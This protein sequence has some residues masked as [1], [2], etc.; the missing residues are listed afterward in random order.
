MFKYRLINIK[1]D[2]EILL[3]PHCRINYES[4]TPYSGDWI[5]AAIGENRNY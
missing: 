4:E 2:K 3:K 1:K 5:L